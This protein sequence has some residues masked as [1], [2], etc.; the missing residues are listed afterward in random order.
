MDTL[1][2]IETALQLSFSEEQRQVVKAYGQPVSIV[3][4]AGAGKTTTLIAKLLYLELEHGVKPYEMLAISYTKKAVEEIE[5]RYNSARLKM[6]L[7]KYSPVFT[8]FHALFRRILQSVDEYKDVNVVDSTSYIYPLLPVLGGRG[9]SDS[10]KYDTVSNILRFRSY[11]INRGYTLTG[12]DLEPSRLKEAEYLGMDFGESNYYKIVEAY[13]QLKKE[14]GDL[15]FDDLQGLC[16][17]VLTNPLYKDQLLSEFAGAYSSILIDE[18]QDISPVQNKVMSLLI[19]E[20]G[21]QGL[22]VIGDD[23]QCIYKFR[24]AEPDIILDFEF[25]HMNAKRLH[26]A[27]NYRCPYNILNF[28]APSI[29]TNKKRVSK[30][31]QAA[32]PGGLVGYIDTK[33]GYESFI[34]EVRQ[35]YLEMGHQDDL[36]ILVRNNNQ[37]TLIADMLARSNMRV[38]IQSMNWSLYE[39]SVYKRLTGII[40][41]IKRS[42]NYRFANDYWIYAPAMRRDEANV[43]L[44]KETD[45]I[46]D[47][48]NGRLDLGYTRNDIIK[49]ILQGDDAVELLTLAF[50]LVKDHY[51]S[52]SRRGFYNMDRIHETYNYILDIA[53]NRTYKEFLEKNKQV[54]ATLN[55]QI[56]GIQTL[57]IYTMHGVKGLEFKNVYI[58][59][60]TDQYMIRGDKAESVET[61]EEER[62]LF[63]VAVTRAMEKVVFVHSSRESALFVDECHKGDEGLV[64]LIAPKTETQ[65]E[66]NTTTKPLPSSSSKSDNTESSQGVINLDFSL[67]SLFGGVGTATPSTTKKSDKAN[68]KREQEDAK[69]VSA[70]DELVKR[71]EANKA[72]PSKTSTKKISLEDIGSLL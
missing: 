2:K 14:N 53:K 52:G 46:E 45:W 43:Y 18:Y 51:R 31:L 37:R 65:G 69:K 60:A 59:N 35:D 72:V 55:G 67:D 9:I 54:K 38:D 24:G 8:T 26:L 5:K 70:W 34:E 66:P 1:V 50:S 68:T 16:V 15:D 36:A 42:D 39:S 6:N 13:N 27:T 29:E 63:Y 23:D 47:V 11:A 30:D 71:V 7:P 44:R 4:C 40:R 21:S 56:G 10:T 48:Y 32:K 19:Q 17:D 57:G 64:T 62:R 3:A 12:E 58:F 22:I 33:D 49:S 41:T 28:V 20:I 61:I 25:T